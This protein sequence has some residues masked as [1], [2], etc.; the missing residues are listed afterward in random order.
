MGLC[1]GAFTF[2]R[3]RVADS[4]VTDRRSL[5]EGFEKCAFLALPEISF[6]KAMGWSVLDDPLEPKIGTAN[7]TFGQYF[8]FSMR[9]DRRQ[10]PP[11]LLKIRLL[12]EERKVIREKGLK[13]LPK[14]LSV[15]L[16][17]AVRERI[18]KSV[19][20]IP[21]FYDVCWNIE[22]KVIWI[23]SIS[24]QVIGDFEK[25]FHESFG[26]RLVRYQ[27]EAP[28]GFDHETLRSLDYDNKSQIPFLPQSGYPNQMYLY[29]EFLTWLWFKAEEKGGTVSLPGGDEVGIELGRRLVLTSGEG[30][31]AE[32]IICHGLHTDNREARIALTKGKMISEARLKISRDSLD[33]ELTVKGDRMQFQ[34]VRLPIMREDAEETFQ[35]LAYDRIHLVENLLDVIDSLFRTFWDVRQ[36]PSWATEELP[37]LQRVLAS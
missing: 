15:E 35:G 31:Y 4:T 16:K 1:K 27:P 28:E 22:K 32:T 24:D 18:Q 8:A 25:L 5:D 14:S 13:K 6:E 33:W 19:P 26:F 3:F 37:R 21:V 20:P 11:S 36:S 29:R 30:E 7:I 10:V 23:G 12:E 9:I 2:T 17:E 34:T